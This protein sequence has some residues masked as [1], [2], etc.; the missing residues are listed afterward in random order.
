MPRTHI[1]NIPDDIQFQVEDNTRIE[2]NRQDN[3][4]TIIQD[5]QR[6][7]VTY[8]TIEKIRSVLGDID[9]FMEYVIAN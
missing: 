9:A 3:R 4:A 1:N 7:N 6:I 5:G 2:W 8:D